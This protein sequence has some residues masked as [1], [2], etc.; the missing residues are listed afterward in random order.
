MAKKEKDPVCGMELTDSKIKS[1]YQGK[2]YSFCSNECKLE[3]EK[4]PAKYAKK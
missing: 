3:F 4:D 2:E 1:K